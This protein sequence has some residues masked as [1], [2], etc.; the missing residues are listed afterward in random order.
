MSDGSEYEHVYEEQCTELVGET[1]R[2][3]IEISIQFLEWTLWE[4]IKGVFLWRAVLVWG[5]VVFSVAWLLDLRNE[6]WIA[7]F[8]TLSILL[9]LIVL[10]YWV[11]RFVFWLEVSRQI[12]SHRFGR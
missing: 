9:I 2:E 3:Q 6:G 12:K 5:A 7:A 11:S 8:S 10:D 1:D 4:A